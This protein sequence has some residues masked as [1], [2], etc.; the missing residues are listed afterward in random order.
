MYYLIQ[1]KFI[2]YSFFMFDLSFFQSTSC[3]TD[4]PTCRT[5]KIVQSIGFTVAP[6]PRKGPPSSA[7]APLPPA[8][9]LSSSSATTTKPKPKPKPKKPVKEVVVEEDEEMLPID[10]D[11]VM[12]DE[13]MLP[14]DDDVVI[15]DAGADGRTRGRERLRRL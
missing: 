8:A 14:I 9:V 5:E 13:E 11:V 15:E 7:T 2:F 10:D 3:M 1:Y 12:E 6:P 4:A